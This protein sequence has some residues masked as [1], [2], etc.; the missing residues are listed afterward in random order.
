MAATPCTARM[1]HGLPGWIVCGYIA[2]TCAPLAANNSSTPDRFKAGGVYL[3]GSCARR[4]AILCR[5]ETP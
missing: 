1:A 3:G 2:G 4:V 5:Q